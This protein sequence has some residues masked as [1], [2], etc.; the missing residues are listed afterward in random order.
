MKLKLFFF[1]FL[2]LAIYS[3]EYGAGFLE[4]YSLAQ[5]QLAGEVSDHS[6]IL[7][8]RITSSNPLFD[9]SWSGIPGLTGWACFEISTTPDFKESFRTPWIKAVPDYDY[10]IKTKV[11]DL[12]PGTR[13]YY[14]STIW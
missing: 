8:T 1:I 5:G 3:I 14:P 4:P 6:V 9:K 12:Q 11:T 13:C 7:Q 2:S 10:I